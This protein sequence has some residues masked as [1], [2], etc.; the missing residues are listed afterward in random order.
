MKMETNTPVALKTIPV[1]IISMIF[2]ICSIVFS[3][4]FVGLAFGIVALILASKGNKIYNANPAIYSKGSLSMIKTGKI[5]GII[6]T[7]ISG[8][9]IIFWIIMATFFATSGGMHHMFDYM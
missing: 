6:G 8:V 1:S 9:Y 2:G 3:C 5:T 4:F 7:I